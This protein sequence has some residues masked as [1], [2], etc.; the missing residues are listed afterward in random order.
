MSEARGAVSL[1]EGK[2][3]KKKKVMKSKHRLIVEAHPVV[4][5]VP[6]DPPSLPHS[7]YVFLSLPPTLKSLHQDSLTQQPGSRQLPETE[8]ST[9]VRQP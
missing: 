5:A 8:V 6:P 9:N 4:F 7:L 1:A 3:K 2:K